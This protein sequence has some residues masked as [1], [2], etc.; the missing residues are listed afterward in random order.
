MI[1]ADYSRFGICLLNDVDGRILEGI[2]KDYHL[3]E[4]RVDQI[5]RKWLKSEFLYDFEKLYNVM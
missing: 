1:G 4:E 3:V 5:L 2:K